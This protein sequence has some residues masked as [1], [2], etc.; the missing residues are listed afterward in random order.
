MR[1][2]RLEEAWAC[3]L[4]GSAGGPR[5]NMPSFCAFGVLCGLSRSSRLTTWTSVAVPWPTQHTDSVAT[6]WHLAMQLAAR[7]ESALEARE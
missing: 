6:A 1:R 3:W 5:L 4:P 2:T 7:V